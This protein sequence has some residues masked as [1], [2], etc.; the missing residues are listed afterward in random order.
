MASI[1]IPDELAEGHGGPLV[2]KLGEKVIETFVLWGGLGPT[3]SVLDIG[4][5]P[6]RMAIAIGDRFNWSNRYTGFEVKE[7][8]VEFCRKHISEKHPNFHFHH[9][10]VFNALYNSRGTIQSL[11]VEFPADDISIDFCFA[12]SIFTHMFASE[13]AHY[14]NEIGRTT[15]RRVVTT[16]FVIDERYKQSLAEGVSTFDFRHC[17]SE[18]CWYT[19]ESSPNKV[20]GHTWEAIQGYHAAA[21]LE[22]EQFYPGG[23]TRKSKGMHRQDFTVARAIVMPP[24]N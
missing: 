11:D 9:I 15:R 17:H 2:A 13:T 8:D 4:S 20:V 19:N 6:G 23:W 16:W 18:G 21:G 3:D 22:I 5:G 10:D 24:E 14:F 7:S 1:T 12:T